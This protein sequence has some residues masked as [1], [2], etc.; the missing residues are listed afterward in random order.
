M[1][2][3]QRGASVVRLT[4]MDAESL[5][6]ILSGHHFNMIERRD[7]GIWPHPPIPLQEIVQHLVALLETREWFPPPLVP[8]QP[9]GPVAD[10]TAIVCRTDGTFAVHVQRSGSHP[11]IL[12]GQG[13]RIF[14]RAEDAAAAFL[15]AEFRLPGDLDGWKVVP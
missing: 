5:T 7:R 15:K 14:D 8:A 3:S 6:Q 9:D 2:V 4:W 13:V 1:R 11:Y 12:A 10:C